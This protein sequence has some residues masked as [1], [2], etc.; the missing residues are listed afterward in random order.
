MNKYSH[1]K[2][3]NFEKIKNINEEFLQNQGK[4]NVNILVK[5]I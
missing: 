5:Q 1:E 3:S 4:Q 2:D